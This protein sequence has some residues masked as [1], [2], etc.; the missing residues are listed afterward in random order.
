MKALAVIALDHYYAH[1]PSEIWKALTD[2]QMH[3]LWWRQ[4][5]SEQSSGIDLN[6]IWAR[7]A[8]NPAKSLRPSL[9]DA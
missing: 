2:P 8:H 3:A 9:S 7:G 4:E 1:P 5:T 6:S